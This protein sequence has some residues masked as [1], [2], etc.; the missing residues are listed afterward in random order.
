MVQQAETVRPPEAVGGC[1]IFLPS[2]R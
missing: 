1:R 2:R